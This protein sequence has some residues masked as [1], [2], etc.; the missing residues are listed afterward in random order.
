[1]HARYHSGWNEYPEYKDYHIITPYLRSIGIAPLEPVICL[2]DRSHF[3][4]YLMNQR[5]WTE[6][7][8]KIKD[9]ASVASAINRGARYLIV[10]GD[11][12]LNREYLQ[13]FMKNPV[14]QFNRVKI[15]KLPGPDK[16]VPILSG[17]KARF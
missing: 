13:S 4:L 16:A 10:N 8:G 11:E 6:W 14:G 5:G 1:M 9:S 3:T 15:F 7:M 17:S 12:V 2:P